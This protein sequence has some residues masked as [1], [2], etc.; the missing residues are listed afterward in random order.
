MLSKKEYTFLI[1]SSICLLLAGWFYFGSPNEKEP[2]QIE[3]IIVPNNSKWQQ[4]RLMAGLEQ[5]AKELA[6]EISYK[7][8][9]KE[10]YVIQQEEGNTNLRDLEGVILYGGP[11]KKGVIASQEKV[12]NLEVASYKK[13]SVVST[14]F[15]KGKS[16]GA[17]IQA[18]H[19]V[20]EEVIYWQDSTSPNSTERTEG[21]KEE[22]PTQKIEGIIGSVETVMEK[23]TSF[24]SSGRV[25]LIMDTGQQ[26]SDY[27][28]Y[29]SRG[30]D[31]PI[32]SYVID[33]SD[34]ILVAIDR[35]EIEAAVF[36]D[37]YSRGYQSVYQLI[38]KG[39]ENLVSIP[40]ISIIN[41]ENLF[42]K[43][44]EPLLFPHNE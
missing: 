19:P 3:A 14:E 33:F 22:L 13:E 29:T 8:V 43:E 10:E 25:C 18:T 41:Q 5:A 9:S 36:Q 35:E 44:L 23:V 20:I 1:V 4:D 12:V 37:E 34:S 21:L 16:L 30:K 6:V 26:V 31:E 24:S 28:A 40:E 15:Q 2:R 42:S 39:A 38:N 11:L 7:T 27:Q 32:K 17:Y